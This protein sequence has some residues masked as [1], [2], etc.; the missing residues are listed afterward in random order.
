MEGGAKAFLDMGV[1]REEF[2]APGECGGGGIVASDDKAK[3][4]LKN[5]RLAIFLINW[6][7]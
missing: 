7:N 1:V 2:D 6:P 3:E 5:T 4:L